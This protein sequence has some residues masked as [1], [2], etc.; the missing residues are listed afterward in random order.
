MK[1]QFIKIRSN[2]FM[3][4]GIFML[5]NVSALWARYFFPSQVTILWPAIPGIIG[6]SL[7][8]LGLIM[9]YPRAN[10]KSPVFAKIGVAFAIFAGLALS[11]A[12]IWVGSL[13]LSGSGIPQPVP[14]GLLALIA[15]FI[16]SMVSAFFANSVAFLKRS[17][18]RAT[19]AL[20]TLPLAMWALMLV[21]GMIAGMDVGLS[22]DHYANGVIGA[23]FLGI[24]MTLR[25]SPVRQTAPTKHAD[26]LKPD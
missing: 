26:Q 23:A 20:L 11:S 21:V 19:G 10:L 12:A 1:N 14:Q 18:Q 25:P 13:S 16:L 6:L 17:G 8:V 24:G 15:I 5:V 4:A 3:A 2:V 22:L 9:I 7:G